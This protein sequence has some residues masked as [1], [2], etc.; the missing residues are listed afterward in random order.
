LSKDSSGTH[1]GI[2]KQVNLDKLFC[3]KEERKV[4]KNFS[5]EWRNK[6][7]ILNDKSFQNRLRDKT[8]IMFEVT[9]MLH[10]AND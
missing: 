9:A 6:A 5:I 1:R 4:A 3:P 10:P 2:S 7:Y 8:A